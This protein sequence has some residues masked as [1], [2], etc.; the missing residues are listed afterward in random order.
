MFGEEEKVKEKVETVSQASL[1][2]LS[3]DQISEPEVE[4]EI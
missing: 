4:G 3:C 1:R 2:S